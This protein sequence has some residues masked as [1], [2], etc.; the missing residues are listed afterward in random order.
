MNIKKTI[1][2]VSTILVAISIYGVLIWF[3]IHSDA[4][5]VHEKEI[6]SLQNEL[7]ETAKVNKIL[8]QG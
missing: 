6:G 1:I 2:G 7:L 4:L 8:Q 3:G 5:R